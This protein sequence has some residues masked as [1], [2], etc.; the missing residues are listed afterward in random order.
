MEGSPHPLSC[1]P[2]RMP[3]VA[4]VPVPMRKPIL[5]PVKVH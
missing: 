3:D 2:V 4:W 1:P 5:I